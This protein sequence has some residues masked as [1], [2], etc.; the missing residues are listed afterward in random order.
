MVGVVS[1]PFRELFPAVLNQHRLLW[2][3]GGYPPLSVKPAHC[4]LGCFFSLNGGGG[5]PYSF[6]FVQ[7]TFWTILTADTRGSGDTHLTDRFREVDDVEPDRS[8]ARGLPRF[9]DAQ[10]EGLCDR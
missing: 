9:R 7:L 2:G 4:F 10:V 6:N 3:E 5:A 1:P 8:D